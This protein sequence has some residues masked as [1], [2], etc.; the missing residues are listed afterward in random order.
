MEYMEIDMLHL[1]QSNP[2][3]SDDHFQLFLYQMLRGLK[4]I[5]SAHVLHRD[6]VREEKRREEK[7][8]ENE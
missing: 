6:L 4:A 3:L 8:R 7:R 1:F 5:H 2:S